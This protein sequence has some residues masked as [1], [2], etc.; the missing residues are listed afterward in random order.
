MKDAVSA[1]WPR[2]AR[3]LTD[4]ARSRS[5]RAGSRGALTADRHLLGGP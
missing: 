5:A 3:A 2:F 4:P 1:P